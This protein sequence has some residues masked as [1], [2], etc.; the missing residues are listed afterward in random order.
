VYVGRE[1]AVQDL[2]SNPSCTVVD[3]VTITSNA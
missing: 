2:V 3:Q 1:E